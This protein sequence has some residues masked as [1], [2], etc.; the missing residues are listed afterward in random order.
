[1]STIQSAS[2]PE[3]AGLIRDFLKDHR[4]GV[5]ATSDKNGNP[6]AAA[7]YFS[8]DDEYNLLLATKTETQKYKNIMENNHV[9]FVCY[10]EAS[11]TTVQ[12]SG[13]AEKV[14]NPDEKQIA[15]N[16]MYRFSEA[17]SK[18]ELPPIEKLYAGDYVVL[19]L[20][21]QVIKMAIF[22]RPDSEGEDMYETILF[23]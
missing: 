22:L 23:G 18:V 21:P 3:S 12:I 8:A 14:E 19:K 15:M 9:A 13:H 16:A 17:T 10:D 6:H 20:I 1:M 5:L 11:Q 2:S 4:S 7:I